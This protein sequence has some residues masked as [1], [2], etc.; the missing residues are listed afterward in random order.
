MDRLNSWRAFLPVAILL[1]SVGVFRSAWA[2]RLDG[3]TIDEPWHITAGVAYV[4]TG[5]Y[6]LNP[7]HPPLVKIVAGL[8]VPR[9]AF[10][11]AAPISL[12]D[13]KEER[14]FV[15]ATMYV[16]NDA[17]SIQTR[18]RRAMFLFN[19]LLL[20][21]FAMAAFRVFGGTIALASLVFVL[22]DPT[23]AAHW[24]VVMTD[25]PVAVLSVTSMLVLVETL[26]NWNKANLCLLTIALGVTLSVKHSG[27][28]TFGLSGAVGVTALLWQ[29]W[30]DRARALRRSGALL[31]V[32]AGAVGILWS[33][34]CFRYHEA[35]QPIERFNRPLAQKIADVH[36]PVW[37]AGLTGSARMR[38]LPRSYIWGLADI[39]R[40][41][42][43]GR[44]YSTYAFGRLSFME[45]RPFI[46][47]GYILVTLPIPLLFLSFL[48]GAI[49]F[50]RSTPTSDKLGAAALLILAAAML[51][52]LARSAADY[53]GVRHALTVCF[54][55]A[56]FAGFAVR[57]LTR[58]HT[59][60]LFFFGLAAVVLACFP[61]VAV[62]R[63]W[64][65]HNL[66]VGGTR[67]AHRYFR[68]DGISIGQRDKEIADYCRR[69]LEPEGEVPYVIYDE[70]SLIRPDLIEY[71][72]LKVRPLNDPSGD[73]LPPS[74]ISGTFLVEAPA[75]APAIWTDLKA[76][77]DAEPIDRMGNL[78]VYHGSYFLPNARA[79]ALFDRADNLLSQATP[80]LLKAEPLLMEGLAL[81][82]NDY[83]GWRLLGNLYLLRG[84]QGQAVSAY[85]K[86]LAVTPPSPVRRL[87]E[88]QI[89]LVSTQPPAAVAPMRDPSRE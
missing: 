49:A 10:R 57:Y 73:D 7:E 72:H 25:L 89:H 4:R 77:R 20:L 64:E 30:H 48:G 32:L 23:V 70:T 42:M 2:T 60:P 43:E 85:L 47:P 69:K 78:L 9:S 26:R 5:E 8:A 45:W 28:I 53:A 29:F 37:R 75:V 40:A 80:D 50:R 83:G 6:Y 87:F 71:R 34:Y 33:A 22:I 84:H 12:H 35:K 51:L 21:C 3:F 61:A 86:G 36:S 74:T 76:L 52:I 31:L 81:R 66:F 88:D 67:N 59:R 15:Q 16:E 62:E 11:F 82:P 17:D 18:V 79:D 14:D 13:K 54:V 38:L 68:N 56:I 1:V 24:P 46:F 55:L 63:P 19:S 44:A 41:G 65:Y 58:L 27:L 39:I